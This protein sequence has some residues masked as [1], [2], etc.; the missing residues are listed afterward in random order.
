MEKPNS[1]PGKGRRQLTGEELECIW[2]DNASESLPESLIDKDRRV[3]D[4]ADKVFDFLRQQTLLGTPVVSIACHSATQSNHEEGLWSFEELQKAMS[5]WAQSFTCSKAVRYLNVHQRCVRQYGTVHQESAR[6]PLPQEENDIAFRPTDRGIPAHI[7]ALLQARDRLAVQT[8]N[9]PDPEEEL[10]RLAG[11]TDRF[12]FD[13]RSGI[14]PGC[15]ERMQ[16]PPSQVYNEPLYKLLF[17][18][19]QTDPIW[20]DLGDRIEEMDIFD[21][22]QSEDRRL[23]WWVEYEYR[24]M[25]RLGNLVDLSLEAAKLR[26]YQASRL[27]GNGSGPM[28]FRGFVAIPLQE[29]IRAHLGRAPLEMVGTNE[30]SY[31]D[32][33][34]GYSVTINGVV[35]VSGVDDRGTRDNTLAD[36]MLAIRREFLEKS[37]MAPEILEIVETWKHLK[38]RAEDFVTG[39][40]Q[41]TAADLLKGQC[42]VCA[43]TATPWVPDLIATIQGRNEVPP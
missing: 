25:G 22:L 10:V 43:A 17:E 41:W 31:L 2:A 20:A 12:R 35:V 36:S 40:R 9:F 33:A 13:R 18:H 7:A 14:W 32:Q 24:Y 15:L 3:L 30:V 27:A 29:A 37:L 26:C 8:L 4:E 39:L 34:G 19:M 42:S 23:P 28:L 6:Q 5:L 1:G 38:E 21:L 11:S 16:L